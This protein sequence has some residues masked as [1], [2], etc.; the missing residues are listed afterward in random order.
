MNEAQVAFWDGMFARLVQ[1]GEVE[2][3]GW[4]NDYMNSAASKRFLSAQHEELRVLLADL[5][6]AK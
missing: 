3:R 5:G 1:T 2:K 6:L 4:E